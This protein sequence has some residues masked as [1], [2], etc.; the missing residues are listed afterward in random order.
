[1]LHRASLLP[2]LDRGWITATL[3]ITACHCQT[4]IFK[5]YRECRMLPQE[6]FAML[7]DA[8]TTQPTFKD[9]HWLRVRGRESTTR[10][11]SSVIKPSNC[12]NLRILLVYSRHTDS[13]AFWG[14]LRQ[15]YCQHSLHRP[16]LL[17][18]GSHAC[19]TPTVWN[20]LPSLYALL[21]VILVLGLSSRLT[22]SQDICS[23]SAVR[24]SDTLRPY[25]GFSRVITSLLTCLLTYLGL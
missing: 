14:H 25:V 8:N 3:C 11:P 19:Y 4:T 1:M 16:T 6:L 9:L 20:S 12:N 22:C 15:T 18:V 21:T 2:S 7:H 13:R 5:G 24:A 23:R 17:L 10:L